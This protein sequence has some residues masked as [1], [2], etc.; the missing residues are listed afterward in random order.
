MLTCSETFLRDPIFQNHL[1]SL[2]MPETDRLGPHGVRYL[3]VED[4]FN[5]LRK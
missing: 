1:S 2:L 4:V 3:L 5:S